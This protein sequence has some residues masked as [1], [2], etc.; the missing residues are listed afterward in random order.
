[1]GPIAADLSSPF[2]SA[3]HLLTV[4]I[5]VD[6]DSS[7]RCRKPTVPCVCPDSALFH[8][9]IHWTEMQLRFVP[10]KYYSFFGVLFC[11]VRDVLKFDCRIVT[12][13]T[14]TNGEQYLLNN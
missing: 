14:I 2:S 4:E 8:L 1:M 11:V 6:L 13:E 12:N 3:L 5:S 10:V 7:L 9:K